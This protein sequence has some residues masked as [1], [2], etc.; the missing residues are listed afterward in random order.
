MT[1]PPLLKAALNQWLTSIHRSKSPATAKTYTTAARAFLS[2]TGNIPVARINENHYS[3]FLVHLKGKSASTEKHYS[4]VIAL[5]YRFLGAKR[6]VNIHNLRD[7]VD[8]ARQTETRR[9][10]K[11]KKK[12]DMPA[13]AEIV[14][15]VPSIQPKD[16]ITARA[17]AFVLLIA[18]S[19]LRAFE[20]CNL[21][22]VDLDMDNK[23][24]MTI[25]KGDKEADFRIDSAFIKALGEYIR[26]RKVDSEW[27]FISHSP[28][29][30]KGPKP[31]DPDTARLDVDRI[32]ML[33][34]SKSPK[35]RI[36]PHQFRHYFVTKIYRETGDLVVTQEAARH[37]N[38]ETTIRYTHQNDWMDKV[39]KAK[40]KES[41]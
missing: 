36:T 17:K 18:A 2:A 6:M 11:R 8:Y 37:S 15:R 10:P 16:P 33:V 31:I 38:V 35:W 29:H 4:T 13:V 26:L 23:R 34:L 21:R 3:D 41:K 39:E 1:S 28:R 5:F 12:M 24:G 20:A 7:A 22:M 30:A 40:N 25:G 9:V 19:G 27:L 32:A 14:R